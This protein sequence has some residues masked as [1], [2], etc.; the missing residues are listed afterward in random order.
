M[1]GCGIMN[2]M[3]KFVPI[4]ITD[5]IAITA[6][7][8]GFVMSIWNNMLEL[9]MSLA[10]GFFGYIGGYTSGT[11]KT[12]ERRPPQ[13]NECDFPKITMNEETIKK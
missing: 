4:D 3:F 9:A 1:K 6:L 12:V 8:I 2:N 7:S 10:T 5:L 11:S 13:L